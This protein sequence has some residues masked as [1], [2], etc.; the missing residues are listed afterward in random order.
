MYATLPAGQVGYILA[1]SGARVVVVEDEGQA[2]KVREERHRLPELETVIVIDPG[3]EGVQSG[4]RSL[5]EV[6]D[7]GHRRLMKEN[8][9]ARVYKE[10]GQAIDPGALATIIYTSRHDGASQ[11][12]HALAS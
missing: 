10:R 4:E 9:L 12:G 6:V 8:G 7:G 5:A 3:P 1:D 2:A 11:R